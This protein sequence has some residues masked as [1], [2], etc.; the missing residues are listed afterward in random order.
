MAEILGIRESELIGLYDKLGY[1][2]F[3]MTMDAELNTFREFKKMEITV[4]KIETVQDFKRFLN[5]NRDK[6]LERIVRVEELPPEDEWIRDD[7]W[8][9][10]L[11][12]SDY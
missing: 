11:R 2:Y 6:L 3:D 9:E 10:V 4:E 1:S 5:N 7:E 8:D 12:N